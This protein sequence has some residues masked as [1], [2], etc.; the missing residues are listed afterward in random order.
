[1]TVVLLYHDIAPAKDRESVGYGGAL[2]ARYKLEPEAFNDHLR[3]IAEVGLTVGVVAPDRVYP[4]VAFSFDDGGSSAL[5]VAAELERRGWRGHFFVPTSMIGRPGFLTA[6][7]IRELAARGH[8]LGA[9]SHSHPTYMAR[10][11]RGE[12]EREWQTSRTVLADLLGEPPS[13]ASVPGGVVSRAVIAAAADAGYEVLMTSEPTTRMKTHDGMGVLGRYA[14]WSTTSAARAAG[15]AG[16]AIDARA[17]L[18]LEWR[19]KSLAKK[20]SPGAYE[21]L[22]RLRAQLH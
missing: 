21:R 1:M 19:M 7:G 4:D 13:T 9:H 17:R 16:G 14:V 2:A 5:S 15:Y 11:P 6:D 3:A 8:I 22:R 18:W 10:L 12:V 20:A